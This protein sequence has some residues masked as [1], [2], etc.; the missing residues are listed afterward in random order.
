MVK[1]CISN[2][3]TVLPFT[4]P[5]FTWIKRYSQYFNMTKDLHICFLHIPPENSTYSKKHGDQFENL[6]KLI[7]S[8][9]N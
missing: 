4:N 5:N 7:I 8:Y 1:K 3:I 9:A 2:G 6:I